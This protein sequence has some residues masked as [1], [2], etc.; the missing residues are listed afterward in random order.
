MKN[1]IISDLVMENAFIEKIKSEHGAQSDSY[2]EN[3]YGSIKVC[4][5]NIKNKNEEIRYNCKKGIYITVYTRE[6][7]LLEKYEAETVSKIIADEVK[8]VIASALTVN[9]FKSKKILVVG[10]GNRQIASDA[11]G[12]MTAERLN[13]TRYME[14]A[15][16]SVFE[17]SGMCSVSSVSCGVMGETGLR[18]LEFIRGIAQQISP[19][20]II[21]IDALAARECSRLA[22]AVQISDGGITPGAGIGNRQAAINTET[23][24][25]PVVAIGV[26]TVVS[27]ATLIGDAIKKLGDVEVSNRIEKILDEERKFFVA[28]K[29]CDIISDS[30]SNLLAASLNR[31]FGV[32]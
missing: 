27:A 13:V 20:V 21:A 4:R 19:D 25:F 3:D 24:G 12:A 2:S 17:K 7:W 23:V 28:P 1:Y 16:K 22:A 29:E 5:L 18:T 9:N 14:L 11:I 30:V 32:I 26:P 10:M 15:D 6:L 8:K 31:A